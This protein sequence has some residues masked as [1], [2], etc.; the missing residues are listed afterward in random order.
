MSAGDR[1]GLA[2]TLYERAVFSGDV[3][4]LADAERGLDAVEADVALARGRILHARFLNERGSGGSS[5]AEDPAELPL[6]E[7]AIELYRALGDVRGEGEA[8]FWIGCLHQVIRRDN[9]AAVPELEQSRRLAAQVGDK[10]TQAEALRHL[11]IAAHMAGR[12]DEARERLEESSRLFREIG[13]L[14][15][16][17]AN[18]IGLAY[19]AAGQDR[20][21]DALATLDE[22]HAI[23]Q[24]HGAHAIARQIEQARTEI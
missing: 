12:P 2:R 22:A 11:G 13:A 1:I 24:A 8:L 17:A 15:V 10:P 4:V 14:P 6:F 19:I 16:V 23:A 5:P 9:E 7:R 21:A 20:R 18:M 3:S